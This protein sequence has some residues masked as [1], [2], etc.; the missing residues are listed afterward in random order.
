MEAQEAEVDALE[1][2]LEALLAMQEAQERERSQIQES[3]TPKPTE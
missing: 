2:E 3:C 1:E